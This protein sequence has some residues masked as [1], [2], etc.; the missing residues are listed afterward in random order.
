MY[1]QYKYKMVY[2]TLILQLINYCIMEGGY[3]GNRLTKTLKKAVRRITIL[4]HLL[5]N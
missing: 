4:S 2:K 1:Y 5:S 3:S